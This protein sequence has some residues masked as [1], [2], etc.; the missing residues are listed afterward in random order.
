MHFINGKWREGNGREFNSVNLATDEPLWRG[1]EAGQEEVAEAVLA[2][3]KSFPSWSC[4][5]LEERIQHLRHYEENLKQNRRELAEVISQET[6]KPVWDSLTEV[7][8]MIQKIAN[9]LAAYS[10]RCPSKEDAL[11]NTTLHVHH[12]P[13][14]VLAIFGPFNF[15]GHLPNGHIVPALLAGNTVV[16]K[17]S[18]YTPSVSEKMISFWDGLPPGVIQLIQGGASTG[19]FLLSHP[20]IDGLLFTGSY[21]T[22]Q[23]ILENLGKH[24][25]KII[26]LEMGGNNPLVFSDARDLD[27][28]AY[29]TLQSAFLTAGQRCTCARRLIIVE[30]KE[31][32]AFLKRVVQRAQS[33]QVGPHTQKPEPFMGPVISQK[34]ADH[35][36]SAQ[37][38][39]KAQGGKILLEMR[40]LQ[41]NIPLVSPGIIDVTHVSERKDEELFGPLLQVIR[42]PSFEAAL[43]EANATHY[44]LVAS[45]I[46]ED[47]AQFQRF[48]QEV[49]AGVINWNTATTGASGKAPFGG[50]GKSGNHRP[51]GY[52]AADYCAYP[53]A[54]MENPMVFLPQQLLPGLET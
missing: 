49:R 33:I 22:G 2:A 34:S 45:L 43:V 19:Q 42:V 41:K 17:G 4:L 31:G 12:K 39:L 25:E 1:R 23:H 20:Q 46:S 44:G 36:L 40:Q 13:H 5:T 48:Y 30:G 26:A 16:F 15:P 53:V 50:I 28:A 37:S 47:K 6:G 24:P 7:A 35:L 27:A 51:S 21:S 52:Y 38:T 29:L 10:E 3:R 54:S 18:E 9:S 11:E 32:E 14:G 8:S